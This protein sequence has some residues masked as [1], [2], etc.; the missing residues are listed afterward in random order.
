MSSARAAAGRPGGPTT[1]RAVLTAVAAGL[2]CCPA[3]CGPARAPAR[4]TAF[5]GDRPAVRLSG[6]PN[7]R[8]NHS[9][10]WTGSEMIVWGGSRDGR[11]LGTAPASSRRAAAGRA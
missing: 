5:G 6:A 11:F 4:A 2:L 10:V 1:R 8:T 9:A 3:A 7:V